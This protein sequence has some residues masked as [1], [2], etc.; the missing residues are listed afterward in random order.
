[1]ASSR[2]PAI[3][4]ATRRLVMVA[5]RPHRAVRTAMLMLLL[6]DQADRVRA[7]RSGAICSSR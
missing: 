7:T 5:S 6:T 2:S 4:I 3:A 1:V